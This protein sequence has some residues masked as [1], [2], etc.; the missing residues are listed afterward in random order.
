MVILN[1]REV[2]FDLFIVYFCCSIGV[3]ITFVMFDFIDVMLKANLV[4]M[5]QKS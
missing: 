1:K 3:S 2:G 4:K 5:N